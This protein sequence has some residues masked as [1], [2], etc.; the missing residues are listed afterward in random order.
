MRVINHK[1]FNDVEIHTFLR[2][3]PPKVVPN[4]PE[5]YLNVTNGFQDTISMLA[6]E[7]A[8]VQPNGIV[9]VNL[10]AQSLQDDV[11]MLQCALWSQPVVRIPECF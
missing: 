1:R 7:R 11:S 6:V 5:F 4:F 8:G 9:Q 2:F 3:P 10:R